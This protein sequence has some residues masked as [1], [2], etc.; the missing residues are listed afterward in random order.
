MAITIRARKRLILLTALVMM[1]SVFVTGGWFLRQWI[2]SSNVESAKVQGMELWKAHDYETALPLLSLAVTYDKKNSELLIALADTRSRVYAPNGKHLTAAMRYY[3]S[4]IF[5]DPENIEALQGLMRVQMEMG[6]PVIAQLTQTAKQLH[7]LLPEDMEPIKVLKDIAVHRGLFTPPRNNDGVLDNESAVYWNDLLIELEPK[8]LR[9]RTERLILMQQGKA[10]PLEII[11]LAEQWAD[12]A[13]PTDGSFDVLLAQVYQS[14]DMGEEATRL[15]V[16]AVEKGIQDPIA[17]LFAIEILQASRNSAYAQT[18]AEDGVDLSELISGLQEIQT[19]RAE[20]ETYLAQA[21]VR[22]PWREGQIA[23][24]AKKLLE[25]EEQIKKEPRD[26]WEGSLLLYLSGDMESAHEWASALKLSNQERTDLSAGQV[27]ALSNWI[28]FLDLTQIDK[29]E[30][31]E[32]DFAIAET[33]EDLKAKLAQVLALEDLVLNIPNRE[34]IGIVVG[35]IY[36]DLGMLGPAANH[37]S[38]AVDPSGSLPVTASRRLITTLLADRRPLQALPVSELLV[39]RY[40]NVLSS[41]LQL[42]RVR[43]Q[44]EKAG[45]DPAAEGATIFPELSSYE[46]INRLS[47]AQIDASNLQPMVAETAIATGRKDEAMEIVRRTVEDED[48]NDRALLG[49]VDL[50]IQGNLFDDDVELLESAL[51]RLEEVSESTSILDSV[52]VIRTGLLRKQGKFADSLETLKQAFGD[53]EDMR[54]KQILQLELLDYATDNDPEKIPEHIRN[55]LQ[56]EP[57]FQILQRVMQIAIRRELADL[58]ID[59]YEQIKE[60]FGEGFPGTLFAESDLV[61][62]F[63]DAP[64]RGLSKIIADLE[65]LADRNPNSIDIASRQYQL[66]DRLDP[67]DM[68]ASTQILEEVVNAHPGA[69][70]FYPPLIAHLQESGRFREAE[71]YVARY[72]R[73]RLN[74]STELKRAMAGLKAGQG[75]VE[76][77]LQAFKE[78]AERPD[79][80]ISDKIQYLDLLYGSMNQLEADAY[81]ESL[82]AD[83]DHPLIVDLRAARRAAQLNGIDAGL[84]LL[85]KAKGFKGDVDRQVAKADLF[86]RYN[87][88]EEALAELSYGNEKWVNSLDSTFLAAKCLRGL[89]RFD[90]AAVQFNEAVRIAEGRQEMLMIIINEHMPYPKLRENIPPILA[91]IE[92]QERVEIMALALDAAG[93]EIAFEPDANQLQRAMD[94]IRRYPGSVDATNLAIQLHGAADT[95]DFKEIIVSAVNRFPANAEFPRIYARYLLSKGEYERSLSYATLADERSPGTRIMDTVLRGRGMANMG[96]FAAVATMMGKLEDQIIARNQVARP[97]QDW[98]V[99]MDLYLTALMETNRVNEAWRVLK[100]VGVKPPIG[101]DWWRRK[102]V[103]L[104][105]SE[106][107]Q[108]LNLLDG[109]PIENQAGARIAMA[110]SWT[111]LAQQTGNEEAR[112]VAFDR[113]EGLRGS[114]ASGMNPFQRFRIE[115]AYAGIQ[116]MISPIDAM[117]TYRVARSYIP[118]EVEAAIMTSIMSGKQMTKDLAA[119]AGVLMM[120]LNN[121]AALSAKLG[122]DLDLALDSVNQAL[123]IS[124]S[125]PEL[126]DTRSMVHLAANQPVK[127]MAD[128]MVAEEANPERLAF[129]LTL[130]KALIANNELAEAEKVLDELDQ[131][132]LLQ[133]DSDLEIREEVDQLRNRIMERIAG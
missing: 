97:T 72:E 58:A 119:Y 34:F 87:L 52:A 84:A 73:Y 51:T 11:D 33:D 32:D 10:F 88:W 35:D 126:L 59:I 21:I 62:G 15:V 50:G 18:L 120:T 19:N 27:R 131:I 23:L 22:K 108:A 8:N 65:L 37:Y 28:E 115:V 75:D 36:S 16:G 129:K 101:Y 116:E 25:L 112:S 69:L 77:A 49:L 121:H 43:A 111:Q 53:R 76:A 100:A 20:T 45:L 96:Q 44:L 133:P 82:M 130:V 31:S 60:R 7:A 40:P 86:V 113:V 42:V 110:L 71:D 109:E 122:L 41:F 39:R 12:E 95:D 132:S 89:G 64:N 99:S 81:L 1:L 56:L 61:L 2:R 54:G 4:V 94:L 46:L 124:P 79:A 123:A 47:A 91:L 90:E 66:L 13:D 78:L 63:P 93:P 80:S 70:E 125:S 103:K 104:P 6:R 127:A 24:A 106:G 57:S 102:A 29:S 128:A 117:E 30:L 14:E 105:F 48:P 5:S 118:D 3:G 68:S 107:R 67:D 92:D 98:L 26:I 74:A 114:N 55:I 38:K 83:P 9:H 85:D 17:L